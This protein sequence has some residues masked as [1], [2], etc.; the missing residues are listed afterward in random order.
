MYDVEMSLIKACKTAIAQK[1]YM[2]RINQIVEILYM[3]IK[4]DV[5]GQYK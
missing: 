3:W 5:A 4:L 2:F 1:I